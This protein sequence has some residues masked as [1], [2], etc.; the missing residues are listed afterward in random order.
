MLKNIWISKELDEKLEND[1][2]NFTS[3]TEKGANLTSRLRYF[4]LRVKT[5]SDVIPG[6]LSLSS[7]AAV[8]VIFGA[9]SR[10]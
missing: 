9:I 7:F 6:A 8:S 4:A 3:F 5:L 10:I 1:H 2:R